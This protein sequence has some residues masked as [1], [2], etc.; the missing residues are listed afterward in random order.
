LFTPR[1]DQNKT[2]G[3][4][5]L[6]RSGRQGN[7]DSAA[8]KRTGLIKI[9]EIVMKIKEIQ[10]TLKKE[11]Q[12]LNAELALYTVPV[13]SLDRSLSSFNKKFEAASQVSEMEEK[14]VKVRRVQQQIGDIEH[15]LEKIKQGTYGLCDVCEKPIAVER[16]KIMPQA[17]LCLECKTR[18]NRTIL[19]SYARS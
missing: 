18:Q 10:L 6:R 4:D 1:P 7:S 11:Q 8:G 2:A 14:M 13:N 17:A 9:Q 15:A 3:V 19:R 12:R 5:F 16:L